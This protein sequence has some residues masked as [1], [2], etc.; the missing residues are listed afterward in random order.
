MLLNLFVN[1]LYRFA[2]KFRV[3][4]R[5]LSSLCRLVGFCGLFSAGRHFDVVLFQ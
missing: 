4:S 2:I 5:A 3:L 1:D